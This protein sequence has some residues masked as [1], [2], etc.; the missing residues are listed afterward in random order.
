MHIDIEARGFWQVVTLDIHTQI[1]NNMR[2]SRGEGLLPTLLAVTALALLF[3]L[4]TGCSAHAK[5]DVEHE[6]VPYKIL[7]E[8]EIPAKLMET[9]EKKKA[10]EFKM[11]FENEDGLYLAHGYG[12]QETGG[13]SIAVRELYVSE[14]ALY[15]DTELLGPEHGSNP[16]KKPSY[17]YI[18]VKTKNLEKNVVFE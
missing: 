11:S 15:F 13:Y 5:E 9:I 4:L 14:Q 6:E 18:V 7:E 12:Q 3:A 1:K 8:S 17:P 16:Q 2:T 10:A